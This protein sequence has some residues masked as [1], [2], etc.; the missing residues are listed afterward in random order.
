MRLYLF[1]GS[2]RSSQQLLWTFGKGPD[3]SLWE[4]W[5]AGSIFSL[6]SGSRYKH[7][8]KCAPSMMITCSESP[9]LQSCQDMNPHPLRKRSPLLWNCISQERQR[10]A[11]LLKWQRV[12]LRSHTLPLILPARDASKEQRCSCKPRFRTLQTLCLASSFSVRKRQGLQAE[13]RDGCVSHCFD[14]DTSC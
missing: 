6:L 7:L 12:A 3:R 10:T 14:A 11:W 8:F 5:D 4:L 13:K 1:R 9:H 2:W